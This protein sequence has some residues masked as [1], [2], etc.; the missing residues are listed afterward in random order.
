ME[1]ALWIDAFG[2][3]G[4]GNEKVVGGG[5]KGV[6][7]GLLLLR[8]AGCIGEG[9]NDLLLKLAISGGEGGAVLDFLLALLP[10]SRSSASRN[11]LRPKQTG[12]EDEA[13]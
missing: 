5:D 8:V 12:S 10:S 6:L 9:D 1:L 2:V 7:S 3:K 13:E 11:L 4:V